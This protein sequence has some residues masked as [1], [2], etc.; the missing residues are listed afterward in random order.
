VRRNNEGS[1]GKERIRAAG[2]E[3]MFTDSLCRH[4]YI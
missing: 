1:R 4:L 3:D 2:Q